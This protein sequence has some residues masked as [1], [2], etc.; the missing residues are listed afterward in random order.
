MK[1]IGALLLVSATTII[2]YYFSQKYSD[3]PKQI[4]ILIYALQIIETEMIYSQH[5]LY[6]LFYI[7]SERTPD[8]FKHFFNSLAE[9][10]KNKVNDFHQLWS[11]EVNQLVKQSSLNK[12]EADLLNQF[13]KSLGQYNIS[14][15]QKQIHLTM[16]HL[17][18]E[19]DEAIDE[20][21]KYEKMTKSIGFLT[22]LFIVIIFI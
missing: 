2:G 13:G 14:E 20:R 12:N 22:G 5:P 10:L 15:Q 7:V 3:R 17:K 16:T 4:R 21:D 8:P 1:W 9:N 6:R 11:E 19:L 18:R